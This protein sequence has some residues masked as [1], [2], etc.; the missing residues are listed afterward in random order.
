MNSEAVQAD[1]Y[2]SQIDDFRGIALLMNLPDEELENLS[3][4]SIY[5]PTPSPGGL[6]AASSAEDFARCTLGN[7]IGVGILN[8]P[9]LVKAT[10]TAIKAYNWGLAAATVARIAG[11]IALKG[12]GGVPGLAAQLGVAAWSCRG[13]L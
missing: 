11:P 13:K 10:V 4:T 12:A 9:G 2:G 1:G 6:A 5:T 8:T 3:A 7:A